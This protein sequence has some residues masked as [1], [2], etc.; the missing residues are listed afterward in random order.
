LDSS[1]TQYKTTALFHDSEKG[2]FIFSGTNGY[3]A[4]VDASSDPTEE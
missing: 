3:T 1:D 2:K 4:R